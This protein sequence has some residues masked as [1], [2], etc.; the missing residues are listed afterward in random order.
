MW[1]QRRTVRYLCRR[2]CRFF[3]LLIAI[4]TLLTLWGCESQPLAVSQPLQ[5]SDMQARLIKSLQRVPAVQQISPWT[6]PDFI[7]DRDT[8]ALTIRTL[9][10][11]VHSTLSD[12][13]VARQVPVLLESAYRSYCE[14]VGD[15][16]T[17]DAPLVVYIFGTR[18]QWED[19]TEEWT[20][21]QAPLYMQIQRGA[22]YLNGATVAYHLGR[23]ANFSVLAHEGWH[24]FCDALFAFRLPSWLDEGL[25]TSFEAYQWDR[26]RVTFNAKHNGGRLVALKQGLLSGTFFPLPELLR[27]D[28]GAVLSM[29]LASDTSASDPVVAAYYGQ[30]YALMRFLNEYNYGQYRP[31]LQRLLADAHHGAWPITPD[32][33]AEARRTD[34]NPTRR[35]N[36]IVGPLLFQNYIVANPA[37]LEDAYRA[38]CFKITTP[39][40]LPQ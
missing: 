36:A 5:T 18:D 17:L 9:H 40:K 37:Q 24:Q 15:T 25:A 35:W 27:R 23:S 2:T 31:G 16:L 8:P 34:K 32:L 10:Y 13:L 33:Q 11:Q 12:P 38:F 14:S 3:I 29:T 21:T 22:Y 28:P 26:G 6:L 4:S 7:D 20:G 30:V 39:V 19:F 1:R